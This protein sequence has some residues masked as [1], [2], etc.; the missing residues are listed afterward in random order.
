[1]TTRADRLMYG[2][3]SQLN[4]SLRRIRKWKRDVAKA[5]KKRLEAEKINNVPQS[6]Q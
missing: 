4:I 3:W 1:M 5:E 2:T 6:H